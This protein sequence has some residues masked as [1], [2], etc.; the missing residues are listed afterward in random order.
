MFLPL[1]QNLQAQVTLG[2]QFARQTD[3][4]FLIL[5]RHLFP[6]H[7]AGPVTAVTH[8]LHAAYAATAAPATHR[9]AL[10]AKLFHGLEDVT[11]CRAGE[12]LTRI[13]NNNYKSIRVH[14]RIF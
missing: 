12:F 8:D 7:P 9:Y 10:T 6:A 3:A 13:F 14:P 5:D 4:F 2:E 11:L 1:S